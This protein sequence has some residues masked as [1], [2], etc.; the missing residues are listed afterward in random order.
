MSSVVTK[1]REEKEQWESWRIVAVAL[2][3]Q[4]L[5]MKSWKLSLSIAKAKQGSWV[6]QMIACISCNPPEC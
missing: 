3:E 2:L 6:L 4:I 1:R 5:A